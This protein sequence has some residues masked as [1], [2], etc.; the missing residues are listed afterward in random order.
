MNFY[1]S[2]KHTN[3]LV[4]CVT[5]LLFL[6]CSIVL[7]QLTTYARLP[8]RVTFQEQKFLDQFVGT[9]EG[10][11]ISDAREVRDRMQFQPVLSQHFLRFSHKA[12]AGDDYEGEGY[13]WYNPTLSSYEWWEFNNGPWAV[14]QYQGKQDREQLILR[15]ETRDRKMQL[16]FA[17]IDNNTLEMTEAFV[18]DEQL[19][20]YVKLKFQRKR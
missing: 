5:L 14:R 6:V 13:V 18:T 15:E 2:R 20:P 12:I 16:S 7:T 9:W 1:Q 3:H 19:K 17:F 11:G 8:E 10:K 4:I